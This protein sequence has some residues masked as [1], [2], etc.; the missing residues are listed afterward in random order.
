[1][2]NKRGLSIVTFA[3]GAAIYDFTIE[4]EGYQT[5]TTEVR[6]RV[7]V[8]EERVFILTPVGAV[9][10]EDTQTT[11]ERPAAPTIA[12]RKVRRYNEGVEAQQTSRWP[13]G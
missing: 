3:V 7:G 9:D 8:V 11:V 10:A 6:P 5:V 13:D 4:M 2:T 1:M 12:S